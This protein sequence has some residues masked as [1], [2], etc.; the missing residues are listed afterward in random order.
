MKFK[1]IEKYSPTEVI[2][3]REMLSEKLDK[4]GFAE[5]TAEI[6]V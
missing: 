2:K 1:I 5:I 4:N 6:F 3:L